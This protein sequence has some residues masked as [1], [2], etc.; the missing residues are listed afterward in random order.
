M[1]L[2]LFIL[3]QVHFKAFDVFNKHF[4]K[5]NYIVVDTGGGYHVLVRTCKIQIPTHTLVK[6]LKIIY[7]ARYC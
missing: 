4:G 7:K 6:K 1:I 2:L 5:G 3:N